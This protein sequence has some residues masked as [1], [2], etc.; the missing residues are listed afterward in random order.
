MTRYEDAVNCLK[1]G[2]DFTM[3][4]FGRSMVPIIESGSKLTFRQTNDYRIGDVVLSRVKGRW[5]DAHK[6]TK[7]DAHGR[8]MISNNRGH[9]N[10]W[11]SKVFGRVIAIEGE[12]FG[13]QVEESSA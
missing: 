7:I 6:I 10:G 8:F 9:D 4:V 2:Q 3:Q 12:P 5:V 13:R 1:K 11:A